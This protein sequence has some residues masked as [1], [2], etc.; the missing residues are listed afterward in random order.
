MG[1]K[2]LEIETGRLAKQADAA[3]LARVGGTVLLAAVTVSPEPL[4]GRDFFPLMVDYREKFYASG[5]I[6]GGFFKREGR[7]GDM[8]TLRARITDR[9]IRPLFPEGMRH[10]VM[11]YITVVSSD[12]VNPAEIAAL[13]ATSLALRLSSVPFAT[14]TAA[15]RVGLINGEYILNPTF[16]QQEESDLD[17]TVA[18]TR[19]A[20][21]MVE[22]GASELD[23]ETVIAALW[24]SPTKR[25]LS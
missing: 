2:T 12:N 13:N 17:L 15:V 5:R 18:G 7:P 21:N 19:Q 16:P 4:V 11:V 10:E 8:E 23:E 25:S 14:T 9:A 3:V 22:A 20:I 6:P 1:R 24:N